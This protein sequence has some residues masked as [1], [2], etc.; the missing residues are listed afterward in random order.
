MMQRRCISRH[1]GGGEMNRDEMY[2][3][4]GVS[5]KVLAFG[6]TVLDELKPHFAEID[7]IA[8]L[9]QVKVIAAM[10]ENRVNATHFAAST[11]YGYGPR[12]LRA[13]VRERLSHRGRARPPADHLRHARAGHRAFRKPSA[14]RRAARHLRQALRHARGGHRHSRKPLLS[15][16]VRR[17]LR[18]GRPSSRRQL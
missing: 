15:Q 11:G 7:E 16:G 18:A 8:E 12:Q 14:G 2:L 3:S 1:A 10:Q 9:N 5:E 17:F 6:E 4:L 13:R